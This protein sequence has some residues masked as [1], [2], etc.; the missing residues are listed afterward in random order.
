MTTLTVTI[1]MRVESRKNR[2]EHWAARRRRERPQELAVW[3][4]ILSAV[5]GRVTPVTS[6]VK[7]CRE[8]LRE[9]N[10]VLD[11]PRAQTDAEARPGIERRGRLRVAA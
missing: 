9:G 6:V 11:G 2:R 10:V 1:P 7:F 3:A 8:A 4:N 5:H